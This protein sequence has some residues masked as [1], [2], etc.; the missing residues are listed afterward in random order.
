M[1]IGPFVLLEHY[2]LLGGVHS[3]CYEVRIERWRKTYRWE[4]VDRGKALA[5][6]RR[7]AEGYEGPEALVAVQVSK[8]RGERGFAP[9][10]K[11]WRSR[12][13]PDE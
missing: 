9:P 8:P 3:P 2:G 12:L 1:R 7:L 5:F 4:Y 13:H 11:V 6:L 10:R